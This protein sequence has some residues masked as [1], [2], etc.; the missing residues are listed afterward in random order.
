M[1]A[2]RARARCRSQ[3]AS[4]V[5][6]LN[7]RPVHDSSANLT[8]TLLSPLS[9]PPPLSLFIS[10]SLDLCLALPPSFFPSLSLSLLSVPPLSPPP[11]FPL[12]FVNVL[13]AP[14]A[15]IASTARENSGQDLSKYY[16]QRRQ[17][18]P[19][20][21]ALP[22]HMVPSSFLLFLFNF[23]ANP[24]VGGTEWGRR[25]GESSLVS[26]SHWDYSSMWDQMAARA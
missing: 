13:Y 3:P 2:G 22:C 9:F 26:R 24:E 17:P 21:R 6:L 20:R 11:S 1:G 18:R 5:T 12:R 7:V 4:H 16:L 8:P 23:N 10:F 19:A 15:L 14:F 25:E